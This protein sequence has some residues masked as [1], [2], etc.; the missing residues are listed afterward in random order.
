[1]PTRTGLAAAASVAA[2]L[3]GVAALN[4][5]WRASVQLNK[6]AVAAVLNIT[7][8][9]PKTKLCRAGSRTGTKAMAAA[10][11]RPGD[12][13]VISRHPRIIEANAAAGA[14]FGRSSTAKPMSNPGAIKFNRVGATAPAATLNRHNS[15]RTV[16]ARRIRRRLSYE[17]DAAPRQ[18][19]VASPPRSWPG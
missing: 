18:H 10:A 19:Q 13:I 17:W 7:K 2:G 1:M 5:L 4:V 11:T 15:R 6:A 14:K 3:L 8:R 12:N 9:W 16:R